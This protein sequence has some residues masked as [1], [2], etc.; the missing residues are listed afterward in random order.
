MSA[1]EIEHFLYNDC[2]LKGLSGISNDV[3]ELLASPDPRA[4]LALDY[5][6]YRIALFAEC[7]RPRWAASTPSCSLR[8]SARTRPP[9]ERR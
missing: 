3:R 9:F 1:K 5:F 4:K 8:A 6:V 2:G 7:S